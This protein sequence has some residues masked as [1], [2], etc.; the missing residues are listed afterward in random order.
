MRLLGQRV[1]VCCMDLYLKQME[2]EDNLNKIVPGEDHINS[3]EM[4]T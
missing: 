2:G 1:Y 3:E 4:K